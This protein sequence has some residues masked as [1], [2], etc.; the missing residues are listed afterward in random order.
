MGSIV[1]QTQLKTELENLEYIEE[2]TTQNS[3]WKIKQ[4]KI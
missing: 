3:T 2:E 4:W 1:D